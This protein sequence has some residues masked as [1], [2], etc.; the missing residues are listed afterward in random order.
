MLPVLLRP[1]AALGG[2]GAN[3]VALHVRKA[4]ENG[5]HQPPCAGGGVGPRLRE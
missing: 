2:A 4:A 1:A 3:K 5:N